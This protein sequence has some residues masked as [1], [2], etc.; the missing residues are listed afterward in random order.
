MLLR[1]GMK[2]ISSGFEVVPYPSTP[3]EGVYSGYGLWRGL[4]S[5]HT[6]DLFAIFLA[7]VGFALFVAL[8]AFAGRLSSGEFLAALASSVLGALGAIYQLAKKRFSTVDVFSSEILA[9]I[10]ILAADNSVHEII[11]FSDTDYVSIYNEKFAKN[12]TGKYAVI[13]PSKENYFEIFFRRSD[14]LGGLSRTVVD[15]ATDFYN[16]HMA[17]RDELRELIAAIESFSER[18][19]EIEHQL[20]DV[21]FMIDL[22][23][24]SAYRVLDELIEKQTHK[25]HSWQLALCVG[26]QANAYLIEKMN[27]ED[28]RY[29]EVLHRHSS[30]ADVI[31]R[32]KK[33]LKRK[34]NG[35]RL[36]P[37]ERVYF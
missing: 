2:R 36:I 9:R 30:Y 33:N 17:A 16:F 1:G 34:F 19:E 28:R 26:T 4:T 37:K 3:L 24:F 31:A 6:R 13:E 20:I 8:V 29:A 5:R 14:D 27:V 7:I 18:H 21:I 25:W 15:H 35:R 22:M 12:P 32:L 23:A 11:K 10:R